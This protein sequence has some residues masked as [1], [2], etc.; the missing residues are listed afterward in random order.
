MQQHG[1]GNELKL[2]Q[3]TV[4]ELTDLPLESQWRMVWPKGKKHNGVAEAFK[5]YRFAATRR[6]RFLAPNFI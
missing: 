1:I 4:T 3:L 6:W 2:G 5:Q